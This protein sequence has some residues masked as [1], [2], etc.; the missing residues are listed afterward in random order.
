MT[1]IDMLFDRLDVWRHFPNYQLERRAD[2]FFSLYLP[3]VLEA[4]LGFPI[5]PD[6]VPEFPVRIGTIYPEIPIDKSYKIDYVA[7]SADSQTAVLVELKTEMM[8]RRPEQDEYLLSA[9]MVGFSDL[10]D[11]LLNIFTATNA[12]R[13]YFYLLTQLESMGLLFIP[14]SV[15]EV[16]SR[17]SLYGL[18]A[19]AQD[20]KNTAKE[21]VTKILVVYV[22]PHGESSDIISFRDFAEV[23]RRHDDPVS[24]RFALSLSAWEAIQAG[25]K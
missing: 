11:G 21:K 25:D 3:E 4:K 24:E 7:L 10:L 20:I 9:Q 22:Q 13:K 18:N 14:N 8:S 2:I 16:M 5:L 1:Q 17:S 12:K 15:K 23:V 6:L 19:F